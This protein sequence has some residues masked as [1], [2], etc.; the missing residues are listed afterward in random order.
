MASLRKRA[1]RRKWLHRAGY[2]GAG[3]ALG[4]VGTAGG[5][6]GTSAGRRMFFNAGI[7]SQVKHPRVAKALMGVFHK[8]HSVY[9]SARTVGARLKNALS[10]LR[11]RMGGFRSMK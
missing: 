11:G 2:L 3:A 9:A 5:L 1:S 10:G 6:L 7:K 8:R 4:A